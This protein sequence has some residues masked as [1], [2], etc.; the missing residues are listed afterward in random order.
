MVWLLAGVLLLVLA[1]CTASAP[2]PNETANLSSLA[3]DG[4]SVEGKESPAATEP[5]AAAD[6]QTSG[7]PVLAEAVAPAAQPDGAV[8]S[9]V[10]MPAAAAAL[11]PTSTPPSTATTVPTVAPSIVPSATLTPTTAPTTT[12]RPSPTTEP[13][14]YC[15]AEPPVKPEYSRFY[16]SGDK[17]PT[18][19]PAVAQKHFWLSRPLP[20]AGRLLINKTFPYGWDENGR[21]LLHNGVDVAEDMGTSLLAVADGTVVVAQSDASAWYGWRCD[22]YGHLVVIELDQRWLDQPVFALY[23]H[24][25]NIM[26]EPARYQ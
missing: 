25:L 11:V 20:G 7:V 21:Y 10:T 13:G 6:G 1:A 16:L 4:P 9:L 18:P 5:F 12:P 3:E 17:W 22:W 23:G 2:P 8:E 26:V 14:R 15:P 24:V 19:D